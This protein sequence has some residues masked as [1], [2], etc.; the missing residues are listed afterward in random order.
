MCAA[1]LA[2]ALMACDETPTGPSVPL[3]QEFV[4][5]PGESATVEEITVRFVRVV[6]DSRC[7]K[8]V[9]CVWEGDAHV[10]ID[11][12]STDGRREYDLH[13]VDM[14]PVVHDAYT[15]HLVRVQPERISDQ[16]IDPGEYRVTLRVTR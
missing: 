10:R 11:V 3:D 6:S 12:T 8:D 2:V 4:L 14:K 9:N 13:T 16:P 7:P 15:I 5:A 1:F